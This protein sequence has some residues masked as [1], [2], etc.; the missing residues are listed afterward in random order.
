MIKLYYSPKCEGC[1]KAKEFLDKN[2]IT[3]ES[4][5]LTAKENREARKEYRK[6]GIKDLPVIEGL[7]KEGADIILTGWNK[8][9]ENKLLKYTNSLSEED[10]KIIKERLSDLGYL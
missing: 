1:M 3:Y 10:E 8:S 2:N 6:L 7:K 5:D 4:L 9:I